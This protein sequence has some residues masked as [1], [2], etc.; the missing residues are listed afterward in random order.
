MEPFRKD[1]LAIVANVVTI[2][3][4]ELVW[5]WGSLVKVTKHLPADVHVSRV[6]DGLPTNWALDGKNIRV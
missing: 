1:L 5:D 6:K 2:H 3:V 4:H